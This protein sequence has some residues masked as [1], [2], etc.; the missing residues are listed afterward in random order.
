MSTL[1]V[2]NHAHTSSIPA[3]AGIWGRVMSAIVKARELQAQREINRYLA[4]QPDRLLAD[5]GLDAT[6][7]AEL[8]ARVGG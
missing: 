3:T 2:T 6:A 4:R 7:I 8:R 5:I 1:T